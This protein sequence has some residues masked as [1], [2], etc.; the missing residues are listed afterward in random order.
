MSCSLSIKNLTLH[1]G[2]ERLIQNL[3]LLLEH[4]EKVALIG[5]NGCGKSTLLKSIIGLHKE[6][7]GTIEVMHTPLKSEK[8][9]KKARN[10]IG[11][12]AQQ[13]DDHFIAPSV[14]ED[15]AFALLCRGVARDEAFSRSEDILRKLEVYHLRERIVFELSGGE[16]RICAIAGILVFD[17]QILLLDEPTAGLDQKSIGKIG[18]IL[19]NTDKSMLI[20][21]HDGEFLES[22]VDRTLR[23][24]E[25]NPKN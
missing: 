25:F 20:S 9:F 13:S 14:I 2:R 11:F 10:L 17:P 3:D 4:K 12:L 15:V 21:S 24:E 22:I 16:K 23:L 6:F 19:K 18:E 5:H 8:E 7:E 1:R